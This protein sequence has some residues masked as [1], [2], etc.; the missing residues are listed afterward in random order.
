M[1]LRDIDLKKLN[2]ITKYPSIP[3]YHAMGDGGRLTEERQV[4]FEGEVYLSEKVDGTNSR[5]IVSSD[6]DY[7]IGSREELLH[8]RGDRI[9]NPS[10]GIVD[11]VRPVAERFFQSGRWTSA[12][13]VLFMETYG[14]NVGGNA[15]QYT[16]MKTVSVR[17]F[18]VIVFDGEL[19]EMARRS[20]EEIAAWRENGGQ[21][22]VGSELTAAH[23]EGLG[24]EPTPRLGTV[25][26]QEIPMSIQDTAAWL[27]SKLDRT[28]C[29]LDDGAG[30]APEGIIARSAD[31][32]RIAKLR[33]E[34]YRRTLKGS[35]R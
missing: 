11:A 7:I 20:P 30:G 22:F 34:D 18:D 5:L 21:P 8:A 15:K 31:R 6:G 26:A 24:I 12:V 17:L 23:A 35:R 33:F 14:R 3:T 2:S 4:G 19:E 16:G 32:S 25:T 9:W 1:N 29:A 27:A 28:R 13:M 10:M